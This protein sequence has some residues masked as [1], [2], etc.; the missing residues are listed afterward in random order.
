MRYKTIL[1]LSILLFT[2]ALPQPQPAPNSAEIKL[3]L[4]KLDVL[5][6]V[7]YIAAHP[8]DENTSAIAYF[9]KG[10]LLRTG[11]LS[12][13]RGD[14]GQNLIG[15]EQSEQLGALR[16][17]ELLEARKRDGGEQF[18]TRAI[19]FGY[20]KS[21]QETFEFWD[22]EKLLSDVVWIIRKFRPDVIITRF[23]AT[24]EGGHGQHTASAILAL[25]AFKLAGDSN[26]FKNQLE[27]LKPWQTKRILWNAWL[28]ALQNK[29]IDLSKVPNV[30]LGEY[31]KLLGKSYTE[32]SALSRSMHKS[33]GFGSS[34]IR[35]NLLNYFFLLDGDPV[36]KEL[37]EGIDLSWNRIEG[38]REIDKLIKKTIKDFNDEKPD[39]IL[40]QLI[41][42]HKKIINLK[43]DYWKEIK[44]K[45]ILEIIRSC[46][47]IWIEAI[48]DD[49][50]VSL[51]DSLKIKAS[52]VSRTDSKFLLSNI[53]L[54]SAENPF[55]LTDTLKIGELISYDFKLFIPEDTQISQ[56]YW[57][58]NEHSLG[59]Y[60]VNDQSLIGKPEESPKIN[61]KFRLR[62][63]NE[64]VDLLTP[65]Y[66]RITD[67]VDGEVYKSVIV[68]PPAS[69]N[70]D[71]DIY[72]LNGPEEKEIKVTVTSFRNS[73]SG[74]IK[75]AVNNDWRVEPSEIDFG[76][77]KKNQQKDFYVKV[78]PSPN[79]INS[80]L[81]A[82]IIIDGKEY[83]K[84]IKKIMHKHIL[85][86]TIFDH[87]NSKLISLNFDR[88]TLK[89]IGYITGSGDKIPE[90][91]S[92]LGYNV[93]QMTDD[94][95][96][97]NNLEQYDVIITGI[98][99]FNT[100]DKLSTFKKELNKYVEQGGTLISQYNTT[101]DIIIEPGVLPLKISRERV[102]DENSRVNILRPE[103]KLFNFPFRITN[104]DFN[105]WIQE[106][107][108]YFPN[109]WDDNYEVLLSMNDKGEKQNYGSLLY[110]KYGKGTF[111]YTGLSFFRQIPAGV[112]GAIKLFINLLYSGQSHE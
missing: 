43:D 35:N 36:Q 101:G 111:I 70:I 16:T 84:S 110:A 32:V 87:S 93:I 52:I 82:K 74:K 73:L 76:I 14:G 60:K 81:S 104:E 8:D 94:Q 48:A 33:Q 50:V 90:F 68:T 99:A 106:R 11:Y 57:L 45:E 46:A 26:A 29:G 72:F 71:K 88:R 41:E 91:L 107:G 75:F 6:S 83:S 80:D 42:I 24:G 37:F 47:G 85:P 21:P 51:N 61:C 62:Y 39:L 56:P 58:A 97:A 28:P 69:I 22:K 92:D 100:R 10:K 1:L 65:V 23:P 19:D 44:S 103:H 77:N 40:P 2:V 15:T 20:T 18:F 66:Y 78:I 55:P 4:K 64:T 59:M 54:I 12:I 86:Q 96:N 102:T 95:L 7:L 27:F 63:K 108:L 31:N 3:A 9:A 25:E 38:G 5:G 98:R 30:N 67:P 105:N 34:G 112:N 53:E 13:T 89:K 79:C 49:D 17:Q 109:E